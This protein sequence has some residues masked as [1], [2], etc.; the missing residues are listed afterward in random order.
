MPGVAHALRFAAR[1]VYERLVTIDAA[2]ASAEAARYSNYVP[3][4]VP[5]QLPHNVLIRQGSLMFFVED[6][7]R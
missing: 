3:E 2:Q 5:M 1:N 4:G 7:R 6:D